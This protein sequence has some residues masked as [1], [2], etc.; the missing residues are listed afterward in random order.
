MKKYQKYELIATDELDVIEFISYGKKG[1]IA[2]VILF[3]PTE[4]PYIFNLSFGDKI[5]HYQN[6]RPF[7]FDDTINT[8]NG[9][10]DVVLATV[11]SAVYEYTSKYPYRWLIF[12]GSN[13]IRTRLYRMAITKNYA[14]LSKDFYIFGFQIIND[15]FVRLP[16]DSNVNFKGFIVKK[17]GIEIV[18]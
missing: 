1:A 13:E 4:N 11:A 16:F 10:R 17:E 8:D 7:E 2:K 12:S 5:V 9:D 3:E 15:E 6:K 14:E 18:I